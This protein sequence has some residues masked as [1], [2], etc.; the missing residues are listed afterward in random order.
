[1]LLLA[2][3]LCALASEQSPPIVYIDGAQFYVHTV[4]QGE[5]LYGL[6]KTYDMSE[7]DIVAHNPSAATKL[8]TGEQLRIPVETM[9]KA[10]KRR[11]DRKLRRTFDFHSVVQGE[12]LFA[13]SR[14]YEIPIQTLVEDNTDVDPTRLRP[15]Q[16][17]L[18]RKK[19]IGSEQPAQIE[20]QL[21]AYSNSL[22]GVAGDE[23]SAC[24]IVRAG[25]TFYSLAR[26]FGI[27]EEQLS[28]LNDG[29]QPADLK[30][31]ATIKV[32]GV[33]TGKSLAQADSVALDK[34]EDTL[35]QVVFSA[36]RRTE[37]LDVALLLP[38]AVDG[39]SNANYLEFYQ[40]FL[41][42]ADCV[43]R[44]G[45]SINIDL[46]NTAHD[47]ERVREVVERGDFRKTDLVVGPVYEEELAPVLAFAERRNVPVVSPL[48]NI[49]ATQS[50]ALFQMA[51][52]PVTKWD[53]V[54][55][56]VDGTKRITLV[57]TD[58]TDTEFEAEILALIG[59]VPYEKYTYQYIHPS[60]LSRN[61]RTASQF[62]LPEDGA[63]HVFVVMA[64]NELDVDR[65]LTAIAS[66]DT[67]LT[68]RSRNAPRYVVLG[69]ARW[70][71]YTNIDHTVFF[72][73]RVVFVSTYHAKRDGEQVRAF[74][75]AYIRAF[76][77]LPS[78]YAYRGYDAAVIFCPEM[79]DA[80]ES[81]LH[82]AR[83]SPLQT[84]YDFGEVEQVGADLGVPTGAPSASRGNHVNREW[85]RVN[86]NED[87]T[88]TV[89]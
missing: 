7:Q 6:A 82:G 87:F 3:G 81:D 38:I 13:I 72:R 36:L 74:D 88:I 56:L 18:V 58:K 21:E 89:Q 45:Y 17:I 46:Y 71:R 77:T 55:D 65:I 83:Y 60:Q 26:R 10:E 76:G 32:P 29:M 42:G 79:Y 31:G 44:A 12:T 5:T 39:T 73:N 1:M 20:R 47:V 49:T 9:T 8:R 61:N 51:P 16:R 4:Q 33:Q 80:I 52:H 22:N 2:W 19:Q 84:A 43:K 70:N 59:D 69:N 68:A 14:Q 48:A 53:K 85:M 57:Y 35:A 27:S 67:N 54:A 11:S 23:G 25:E 40:G 86:Y 28:L 34:P 24:H 50:D 37:A 62:P 64:D 15:G 78:L 75:Q 41:L 63:E 66:A 30:A